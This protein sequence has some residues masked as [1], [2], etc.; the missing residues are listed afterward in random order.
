MPLLPVAGALNSGYWGFPDQST[1]ETHHRAPTCSNIV[2]HD[3]GATHGGQCGSYGCK[4]CNDSGAE[5]VDSAAAAHG[6]FS[7]GH[8]PSCTPHATHPSTSPSGLHGA[9]PHINSRYGCPPPCHALHTPK[10]GL[11]RLQKANDGWLNLVPLNVLET[12]AVR[13][14]ASSPWL[15]GKPYFVSRVCGLGL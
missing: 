2:C 13:L 15:V 1:W 4:G 9:S 14:I 8:W 7:R 12:I 11:S 6:S 5:A 10:G 3:A